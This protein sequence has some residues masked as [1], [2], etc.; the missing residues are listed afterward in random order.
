MVHSFYLCKKN[1]ISFNE[2][3]AQSLNI[4]YRYQESS[5]LNEGRSAIKELP[6]QCH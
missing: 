4:S 6:P 3:M 2:E 1:A 5:P